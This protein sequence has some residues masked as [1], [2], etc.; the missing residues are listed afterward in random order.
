MVKVERMVGKMSSQEGVVM[1]QEAVEALVEVAVPLAVL[2]GLQVAAAGL[3]G[4][5]AV[6]AV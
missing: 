2:E 3:E 5:L 1:G 6:A 4:T